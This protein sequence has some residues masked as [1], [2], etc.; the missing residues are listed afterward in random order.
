MK[1]K[2]TV[3]SILLILCLIVACYSF[4][5]GQPG[6]SRRRKQEVVSVSEKDV[7][8]FETGGKTWVP[9]MINFIVP[10]GRSEDA[11]FTTIESYFENFSEN[12]GDAMRIWISSPFLEIEDTKAGEYN[13]VKL[14]R[15]DHLLELA[16]KYHIRIK[17]TLQ[18]VRTISSKE[19]WSNS[20]ALS[21]DNGGPF[22]NMKEYINT[23]EG[24]K[25]YLKRVKALADRY[26]DNKQIFGWELWNEMDAVDTKDWYSFTNEIL[27]SVQAMFPH[28]MVTQTL[29]SLHSEDAAERYEKFFTLPQNEFVSLHRYID[30]GKDWDQYASITQPTDLLVYDAVKFAKDH[31]DNKPVVVNEIGAV[32]GNHVGPSKMYPVDTAGVLIHD[33]VFAPFFCGAAASGSM[34]HWDSYVQKQN[35]WF[36][37]QRFKN[38]IKGVDPAAEHFRPFTLDQDGVRSFGLTGKTKTMVWC[39]DT[40][41]NWKTELQQNVSAVPKTGF[42]MNISDL[43]SKKYTSAKVY[44]PW[45]DKW[46][47]VSIENGRVAFP[48]FLRSA[49]LVIE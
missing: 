15:I 38:A 43:G 24:K 14:K 7:H 44:D 45:K 20:K 31:V 8:Y 1:L 12:G 42:S 22:K 10:A 49:I 21:A 23:S 6:D 41:N 17:F 35:L 33:M 19:S 9:I 28:H 25:Y 13:P 18:H 48:A 5:F 3:K 29:G 32:E 39:R 47:K 27:D 26:K 30:P 34:W 40:A 16:A 2:P 37:Y 11:A 36:H 46:T 4:S